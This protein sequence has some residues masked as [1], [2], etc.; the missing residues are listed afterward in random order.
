MTVYY[1]NP[2]PVMRRPKLTDRQLEVLSLV[3]DGLTNPEIAAKLS[4][5]ESTIKT[6]VQ[7]LQHRLGANGRANMVANGFRA[8][9]LT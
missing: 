7:T 4:V 6:H 5:S 9:V 3:A 1:S 2:A 8:G